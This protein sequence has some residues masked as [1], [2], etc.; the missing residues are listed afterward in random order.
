MIAI[1]DPGGYRDG[2]LPSAATSSRVPSA[3]RTLISLLAP[4]NA[5]NSTVAARA[6]G[7]VAATMPINS[8][9]KTPP[10]TRFAWPTNW[11]TNSLAG[12]P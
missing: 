1:S 10:L 3:V 9:R 12:W 6:P 7:V 8:G 2:A 4:W 11:A 5:T